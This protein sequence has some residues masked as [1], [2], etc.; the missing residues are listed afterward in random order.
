MLSVNWQQHKQLI[1]G[2]FILLLAVYVVV[3]QLGSFHHSWHYIYS[4]K[5]AWVLTAIGLTFLT[6][7]AAA[8]TYYFLAFKYAPYWQLIFVQLAAMYVNKLL[9]AGVGAVGANYAYLRHRKHSLAE[10][11]SVVAVNNL[12]GLSG[13]LFI[14]LMAVLLSSQTLEHFK[15]FAIWRHAWLAAGI[16]LVAA[17]FCILVWGIFQHKIRIILEDFRQQLIKY[18]SRP[19]KLLGAQTTSIG[20]TVC[21]CLCLMACLNSLDIHLS[22]LSTLV[23]FS[24]GVGVGAVTPT[25]GGL[26]GF[27]AGLVSSLVAYRVPAAT[28]LA[29][30]LLYR[31][32][33]Y[34]LPLIIGL[35]SLIFCQRRGLFSARDHI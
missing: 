28:A 31:L 14:L 22:F 5:L 10:A 13:H 2:L 4:A 30:A 33:S 32:V 23:I 9:P 26:G 21:N 8:G 6:Y 20:L 3:P 27:E 35:I 16:I 29:A 17:D 18:R 1:A 7:L 12:L 25:P 11:G 34:W 19:L 15:P 24:F